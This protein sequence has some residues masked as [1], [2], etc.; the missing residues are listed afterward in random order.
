MINIHNFDL[1]LKL[2]WL[3][4]MIKGHEPWL[5][6]A[7]SMKIDR[8]FFL[9]PKEIEKIRINCHNPFWQDVCRA[10]IK[11]H[12]G[13]NYIKIEDIR[14]IPLWGNVLIN[15]PTCHWLIR[16]GFR[17]VGDLFEENGEIIR[18][19]DLQIR[20]N[21]QIPFTTYQGIISAIPRVWRATLNENPKTSKN[22]AVSKFQSIIIQDKKGCRAIRDAF[23]ST[24]IDPGWVAKWNHVINEEIDPGEWTAYYR[25]IQLSKLSVNCQYS[26]YQIITRSIITKKKLK[27]FKIIQE[28]KCSF[29]AEVTETVE[30][31]FFACQ[32][33]Q[34]LWS[35]VI[36]WLEKENYHKLR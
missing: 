36:T 8:L 33:V 16:S 2:T 19:Q 26:Q 12:A 13:L 5:E 18:L 6:I 29:C 3:R 1:G 25:N 15:I 21:M 35:K 22:M 28:D 10:A 34:C 20:T 32:L 27:Q 4:K 23:Q 7:E 11:L 24:V 31:L 9:G 30:H 17:E 14:K